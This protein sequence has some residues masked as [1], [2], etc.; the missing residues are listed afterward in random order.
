MQ[1]EQSPHVRTGGRALVHGSWARP[2]GSASSDSSPSQSETDSENGVLSDK[3]QEDVQN[4]GVDS[5]KPR[6]IA[7]GQLRSG[8][9]GG[10]K[11][12]GIVNKKVLAILKNKKENN[13]KRGISKRRRKKRKMKAKSQPHGE[14]YVEFLD[15]WGVSQ[16]NYCSKMHLVYITTINDVIW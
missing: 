8:G 2:E 5:L 14:G 9:G 1:L 16:V 7:W 10:G 11:S 15:G 13:K 3:N 6:R 12:A 4:A